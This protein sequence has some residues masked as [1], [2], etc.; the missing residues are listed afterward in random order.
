MSATAEHELIL[1]RS[2]PPCRKCH[3]TEA[4]LHDVA[5]QAPQHVVVRCLTSGDPGAVRYGA[6]LTPM[7]LLNGKVVSAGMVPRAKGL[8]K[9]LG[10]R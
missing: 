9:L 1:I 2:D 3:K 7:V 8:L 6:I 4:V 10:T 5:A